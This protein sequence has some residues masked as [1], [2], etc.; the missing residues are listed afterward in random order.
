MFFSAVISLYFNNLTAITRNH[1]LKMI[2]FT[3]ICLPKCLSANV[4]CKLTGELYPVSTLTTVGEY[5]ISILSFF[6][7]RKSRSQVVLVLVSMVTRCCLWLV[8]CVNMWR[9]WMWAGVEPQTKEWKLLV[10]A[11]Q[12]Q[13]HKDI[14]IW[15]YCFSDELSFRWLNYVL[16]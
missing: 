5:M 4:T 12:G 11:A 2:S 1:M 9:V 6:N 3:S 8:S 13:F 14:N 15:I 16:D 7:Y 10:T